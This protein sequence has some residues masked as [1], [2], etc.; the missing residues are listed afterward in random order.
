MRE[1]ALRLLRE[2]ELPH[3]QVTVM[4]RDIFAKAGI[5]WQD[6]QDMNLVLSGL[7]TWQLLALIYQLRDGDEDEEEE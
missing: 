1:F 4:H 7:N 3:R 2:A 5:V 6:G